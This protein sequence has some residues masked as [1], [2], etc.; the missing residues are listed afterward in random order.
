[1]AALPYNAGL[2]LQEKQV[3]QQ[4]SVAFS[5]QINALTAQNVL[6]IDLMCDSV[7]YQASMFSSDGFHPNDAGYARLAALTL[8]AAS[9]GSAAAPR[10]GCGQMTLY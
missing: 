6:V 7:M 4:I 9:T 2:S 1:M 10:S 3:M 5:A 8:G